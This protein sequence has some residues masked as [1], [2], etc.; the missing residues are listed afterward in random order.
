MKLKPTKCVKCSLLFQQWNRNFLFFS[1]KYIVSLATE[2]KWK[3]VSWARAINYFSFSVKHNRITTEENDFRRNI[4]SVK[5][6]M[7]K[8]DFFT[9][10]WKFLYFC[11]SFRCGKFQFWHF[12]RS[13]EETLESQV[14][15]TGHF[16]TLALWHFWMTKASETLTKSY[17]LHNSLG[18]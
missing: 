3:T 2:R 8:R 10:E 6:E 12:Y 4:C 9:R 1:Q 16:T 5:C 13:L 14:C 15:E 18:S 7:F 11:V 17:L